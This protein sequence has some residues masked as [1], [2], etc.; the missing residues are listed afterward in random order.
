MTMPGNAFRQTQ[1][2]LELSS[3]TVYPFGWNEGKLLIEKIFFLNINKKESP[4]PWFEV[5][6]QNEGSNFI[7][8]TQGMLSNI[9]VPLFLL[10]A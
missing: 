3:Y 1:Q 4:I 8:L 5:I 7:Q 10:A 6:S 2:I 9:F